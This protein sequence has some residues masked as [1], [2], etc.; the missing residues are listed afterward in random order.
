MGRFPKLEAWLRGEKQPT[1]KQL[2]SFAKAVHAPIGFFFLAAP[3][4]ETVP[5]PDLRTVGS[6]GLSRPSPDLLDTIYTCQQRQDWYR[7]H[8]RTTGEGAV[9]FIGSARLTDPP[10]E[11]AE[12]IRRVL[13]F[14]VEERNAMRSWS[15]AR[16]RFIEQAESAGMMV[17]VSGVVGSNNRRKLDPGEFRGFALSDP[18]APLV[19]INGADSKSAQMFTL[20][21]EIA[22]LWL[23]Q[24][25]LSDAGPRTLSTHETERWCN[26]VAAELLVPMTALLA[27]YRADESIGEQ[28]QRLAR[29]FKVSTLVI[30]RRLFDANKLTR[31]AFWEAYDL[32]VQRLHEIAPSG[33]GGNFY[34]TT[35]ARVGKRFASAIIG[36]TLEGRASFAEA[37]RLLGFKKMSTF[38]DLGRV[39]GV[40]R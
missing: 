29:A 35:A 38:H 21:H 15:E 27:E 37:L 3:P 28:P 32:E 14:S 2:E 1:F 7:E 5:I 10:E 39:V 26:Q 11:V 20:A 36:S 22:H 33:S 6:Q 8:A 13:A 9:S 24:T 40:E 12:R 4:E 31:T 23:D 16:R 18:L 17:M 25:A 34:N 30:L 19:F